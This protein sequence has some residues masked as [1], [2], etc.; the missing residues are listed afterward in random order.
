MQ[1]ASGLGDLNAS[2]KSCSTA[3]YLNDTEGV[4]LTRE[5]LLSKLGPDELA[6]GLP[7]LVGLDLPKLKLSSVEKG[8]GLEFCVGLKALSVARNLLDALPKDIKLPSLRELVLDDNRV[9]RIAALPQYTDLQ[10][11]SLANNRVDSL[12][13]VNHLANL[14]KLSLEGNRLKALKDVH[15]PHLV[16]LNVR[17]NSI[18]VI[19]GCKMSKLEELLASNNRLTSLAGLDSFVALQDLDLASNTIEAE[20]RDTYA[21]RRVST[22]MSSLRGLSKLVSLNV[23]N[24]R[25]STLNF[26]PSLPH[27]VELLVS[28]N[29][30]GKME[31]R[32][33]TPYTAAATPMSRASI[34]DSDIDGASYLS[35]DDGVANAGKPKP[36]PGGKRGPSATPSV[37]SRATTSRKTASAT[38]KQHTRRGD[39]R[40]PSSQASTAATGEAG[41]PRRNVFKTIAEMCPVLEVLDMSHNPLALGA[42][43]QLRPLGKC[44]HLAEIKLI[45]STPSTDGAPAATPISAAQEAALAHFDLHQHCSQVYSFVPNV[46]LIDDFTVVK[47]NTLVV[48]S[49]VDAPD[50]P[51]PGRSHTDVQFKRNYSA[52]SKGVQGAWNA[53]GST[54]ERVG[55]PLRLGTP[56]GVRPVSASVTSRPATA[57][58]RPP[59]RTL[60][61]EEASRQGVSWAGDE[62]VGEM[63]SMLQQLKDMKHSANFKMQ[64]LQ[65][66]LGVLPSDVTQIQHG[67]EETE[68]AMNVPYTPASTGGQ[69]DEA[70]LRQM[71]ALPSTP[72]RAVEATPS[73]RSTPGRSARTKKAPEHPPTPPT[74]T[75]KPQQ[76]PKMV[77]HYPRKP[78]HL[79][80]R[81]S[82]DAA[83][84]AKTGSGLTK[85][86]SF[87]E[88]AKMLKKREQF[89]KEMDQR[90]LYHHMKTMGKGSNE[91]A[92]GSPDSSDRSASPLRTRQQAPPKQTASG[93]G[94]PAPQPS[95]QQRRPTASFGCQAG[96]EGIGLR[97]S[98]ATTPVTAAACNAGTSPDAAP[99]AS[100][101][102]TG[103]STPSATMQPPPPAA[104]SPKPPAVHAPSAD[105]S[106]KQ[107]PRRHSPVVEGYACADARV[108][109][110]QTHEVNVLKI[111]ESDPVVGAPALADDGEDYDGAPAPAVE[112]G[113]VISGDADA[114]FAVARPPSSAGDGTPSI[115]PT[116][117]TQ[118]QFPPRSSSGSVGSPAAPHY[119]VTGASQKRLGAKQPSYSVKMGR[120]GPP[121]P[122]VGPSAAKQSDITHNHS[123]D[124]SSEVG[125]V[126]ST[127]SH[128][129]KTPA[130]RQNR[131]LN[132]KM[133]RK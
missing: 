16:S 3:V 45:G 40:P 44:K 15:L 13:G 32:A 35:E 117:P 46:E 103:T 86:L 127:P 25:L 38:P 26:L 83:S 64:R 118:P 5:L 123:S 8:C 73:H 30:L 119:V 50:A 108:I 11:L 72:E 37:A 97:P 56:A 7:K 90:L 114:R 58:G 68:R 20:V 47:S 120:P 82:S 124:R 53:N 76:A 67:W 61:T 81:G 22:A 101:T 128:P 33:Q 69:L 116:Q 89:E 115:L 2:L 130:L 111:S 14:K 92:N 121:A 39:T 23:S 94:S 24:N 126:A 102:S 55:T 36:K 34:F 104:A 107:S 28:Q 1:R 99:L 85:K 112:A 18:E 57:S 52:A 78:H 75:T 106:A 48:E 54:A 49:D 93:E 31:P 100:V 10:V 113:V 129:N 95:Q 88:E 71:E 91:P 62:G 12:A 21:A 77:G 9:P 132:A 43:D 98:R 19:E 17:R 80:K 79:Q 6:E 60:T 63:E 105:A 74:L 125:S 42:F 109:E 122:A 96:E 133:K 70:A 27:L 51:D 66:V 65:G 41:R 84:A 110:E 131:S 87:A 59:M 29:R 4:S